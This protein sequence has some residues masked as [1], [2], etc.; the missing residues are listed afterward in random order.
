MFLTNEKIFYNKKIYFD[1][2]IT[3]ITMF[4]KNSFILVLYIKK[5]LNKINLLLN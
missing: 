2:N 5:M 1:Y 3:M 4:I